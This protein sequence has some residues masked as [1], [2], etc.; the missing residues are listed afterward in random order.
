MISHI[1]GF[2][3]GIG[4]FGTV[5]AVWSQSDATQV[6]AVGAI[7]LGGAVCAWTAWRKAQIALSLEEAKA[8]VQRRATYTAEIREERDRLRLELDSVNRRLANWEVIKGQSKTDA[9]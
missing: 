5:L 1:T 8:E 3:L 7:L 6:V 9:P 4:V 2:F